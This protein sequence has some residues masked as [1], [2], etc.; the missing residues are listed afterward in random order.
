MTLGLA[1]PSCSEGGSD[2]SAAPR[3]DEFRSSRVQQAME[4]ADGVLRT[5]GFGLFGEEWRGFLVENDTTIHE[6]QMRSGTCYVAVAAASEAVR[7]LDLRVFDSD[8]GEVAQDTETGSLSALRYCP[9]QSGSYY[10]AARASAG[11][12]LF[13]VRTFRGPTGLAVR[14]DDLFRNAAPVEPGSS[15]EPR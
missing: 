11:S 3:A 8:G 13:A 10:L 12:G 4:G 7:E 15:R 1:L 6:L 5:R 14:L 9:G 2:S